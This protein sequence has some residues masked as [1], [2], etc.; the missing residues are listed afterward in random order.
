VAKIIT[1]NGLISSSAGIEFQTGA[2]ASL[3]VSSSGVGIG[4]DSPSASLDIEDGEILLPE[5]FEPGLPP[6]GK[7]YL[8]GSG[9]DSHVYWKNDLGDVFD[10]T[11]IDIDTGK[12]LWVDSVNGGTGIRGKLSSPYLTISASF[13]DALSGDTVQ[14]YPGTY[15]ENGLNV[16]SG[17]TVRGVGDWSSVR[18]GTT[19]S[20][21]DIM[22]IADDCYIDHVSFNV[23]TS[24]NL[25]ALVYSG[26]AGKTAGAYNITF[27]GDRTFDTAV[28]TPEL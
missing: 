11:E 6:A 10:L 9:S 18:I 26:S 23:P 28:I 24:S 21:T 12:V 27:Y 25:S 7:G 8:Y 22:T 1:K 17:V 19:S 20:A 2:S 3:Y 15:P 13:A 14:I 5:G 16:P 4:T